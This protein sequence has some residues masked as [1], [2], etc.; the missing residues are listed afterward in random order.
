M[1]KYQIIIALLLAILL[2]FLFT[3]GFSIQDFGANLIAEIIGL[4]LTII[5]VEGIL[6]R[7]EEKRKEK[8]WEPIKDDVTKMLKGELISLFHD[9][10]FF[11]EDAIFSYYCKPNNEPSGETLHKDK[12]KQLLNKGDNL[13][14]AKEI[15]EAI[16]KKSFQQIWEI[17]KQNLNNMEMKYSKYFSPNTNLSIIKIQ[18]F[19]ER[20]N[21]KIYSGNKFGFS[22][23][24]FSS[25]EKLF[26]LILKEIKNIDD[27]LNLF[28]DTKNFLL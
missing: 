24:I 22:D 26:I 17:R 5:I 7:V 1:K 21:R 6:H 23:N 14:I 20:C 3:R 18:Y 9:I 19:L 25:L 27:E 11:S 8:E 2:V 10:T 16:E 4:I 13:K 15:K 28:E 12:L